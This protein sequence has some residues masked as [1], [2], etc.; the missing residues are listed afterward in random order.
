[1]CSLL[2]P[3]SEAAMREA[4]ARAVARAQVA[5]VGHRLSTSSRWLVGKFAYSM[6]LGC[7]DLSSLFHVQQ[8]SD[9]EHIDLPNITVQ[10]SGTTTKF[11]AVNE[12]KNRKLNNPED[13]EQRLKLKENLKVELC[14]RDLWRKFHS[15]G[16]EMI[17]TKAG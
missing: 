17:I 15:L 13:S 11:F 5:K 4:K 6:N 14:S 16:T 10:K 7:L 9:C 1:C 8:T 2:V 12:E 3:F